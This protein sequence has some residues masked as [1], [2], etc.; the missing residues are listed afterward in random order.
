MANIVLDGSK[1]KVYKMLQELCTYC[2]E[3]E[4]WGDELWSYLLQDEELYEEFVYFLENHN[5]KGTMNVE[6]Y[7][8]FDL[9]VKQI[10]LYN[11]RCDLGKNPSF[12][13]KEDM[14]L[15]AFHMMGKL[16][17]NPEAYKK[18]IE[19]GFGMDQL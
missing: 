19:D 15:R 14:V 17:E 18:K 8:L 2:S 11:V 13:I 12:C 16:K 5:L 4:Q 6:G 1:I 3:K 10:D 7:T 9:Y